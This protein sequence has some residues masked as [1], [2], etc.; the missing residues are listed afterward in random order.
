[1]EYSYKRRVI[2]GTLLLMLFCLL[3]TSCLFIK[4]TPFYDETMERE[5]ATWEFTIDKIFPAHNAVHISTDNDIIINFNNSLDGLTLGQVSFIFPS[6]IYEDGTNCQINFATK[7]Y[8]D[9]TIIINPYDDWMSSYSYNGLTLEGFKDFKGNFID[10]F[11]D[12][13]YYFSTAL[14]T[15]PEIIFIGPAPAT[16]GFPASSNLTIIFNETID[17]ES[18][19]LI[20][21]TSNARVYELVNGVGANFYFASTNVLNDTLIIDPYSDIPGNIYSEIYVEGF[22]DIKGSTMVA[23]LDSSY[24]VEF[25]GLAA[26][27]N[28]SGN[29]DDSGGNYYHPTAVNGTLLSSDRYNSSNSALSLDGSTDF[30]DYPAIDFT[31]SFTVSLWI[32]PQSGDV[33]PILTKYATAQSDHDWLAEVNIMHYEGNK[34]RFLIGSSDTNFY[35]E[36]IS[37]VKT[38]PNKWYH[39]VAVC[40]QNGPEHTISLYVNGSFN[41]SRTESF[42]RKTTSATEPLQVGRYYLNGETFFLGRVDD[43][44]I[45]NYALSS[46]EINSLYTP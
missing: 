35:T 7:N 15:P 9:D 22:R 28:F 31:R 14:G 18:V 39:I 10:S 12:S 3:F 40:S 33:M 32:M 19:G 36:L 6:I 29:R 46:T 20:R 43:I 2:R 27:Y 26:N 21:L 23:Y 8:P 34:I 45:Y 5:S 24:N 41:G 16:V 1:M 17:V 4:G 37:T 42:P 30:V 25:A 13:S 38:T 44:R 11:T